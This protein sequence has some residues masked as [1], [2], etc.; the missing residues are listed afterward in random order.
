VLIDTGAVGRME[1][2]IDRLTDDAIGAIQGSPVTDRAR[3]A[4]VDL[5]VYVA[6][7]AI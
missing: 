5:A 6:R 3:S 1:S 2:T 4:L 7:R